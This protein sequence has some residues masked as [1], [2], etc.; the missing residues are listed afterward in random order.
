MCCSGG[1]AVPAGDVCC[2]DSAGGGCAIGL[3]CGFCNGVGTCCSDESCTVMV[4]TKGVSTTLAASDC[5][6]SA[7]STQPTVATVGAGS[8]TNPSLPSA[9]SKP[10]TLQSVESPTTTPPSITPPPMSVNPSGL[11]CGWINGNS[12]KLIVNMPVREL[13]TDSHR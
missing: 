2:D 10:T 6:A 12:S 7:G 3:T 9:T 4:N 8:S 11:T 5:K 13:T 1:G